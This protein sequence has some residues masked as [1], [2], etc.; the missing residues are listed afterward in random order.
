MRLYRILRA[1]G[2]IALLALAAH[3]AWTGVADLTPRRLVQGTGL[4]IPALAMLLVAAALR[5]GQQR[6]AAE[7]G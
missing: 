5:R 3:L 2:A 1:L 7:A 4:A 6:L